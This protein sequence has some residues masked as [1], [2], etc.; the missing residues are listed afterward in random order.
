MNIYS[1]TD[2]RYGG[3]RIGMT[4]YMIADR[5]C[6]ITVLAM[7]SSILG[8]PLPPDTLASTLRFNGDGAVL[9]ASVDFG[10]WHFVW[11]DYQ[12]NDAKSNQY[13]ERGDMACAFQTLGGRHWVLPIALSQKLGSHIILDPQD[14]VMKTM[15]AYKNEINGVAYFER[16]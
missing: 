1:Q 4:N 13:V 15:A 5:G 3:K 14:G 8:D 7:I 11:R 9:W 12:R 2:P 10:K 16:K 6:M